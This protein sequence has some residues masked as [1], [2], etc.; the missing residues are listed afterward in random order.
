MIKN[1]SSWP[2]YEED[3]IAAVKNILATGKVNYWTGEEGRL[4]E[5]EFSEYIGV[6]HCV[7]VMNGTV[8]LEAA[9]YAIGLGAGDDV[10]VPAR[11]FIGTASAVI[12]VG[13]KPIVADIDPISQNISV[14]TAE[15]ALTKNTKAIIVV[16]LAG[17]PCDM[18]SLLLFAQKHNLK[19]IEDCAQAIGAT[20][21]G[22]KIG[23]FGNVAAFSFCQDKIMSTGGEGG[24]VATNNHDIWQK[25]W[26]LKDHGKNYDA[27]YHKK[28]PI[29]FR[30]LVDSFGTNL[31]MTE[32][33]AAIGR[34]QLNKINH[35]I[36]LRRR[37]A[38]ILTEKF[39]HIPA[40][41]ISIPNS[42]TNHVYYTYYAFVIPDK[43]KTNWTRDR[44]IEA[45]NAENIPCFVGSCSEIYL[46]EAFQK[47]QL[48]PASR[49]PIARELGETSLM[50]HVHPMLTE[51]EMKRVADVVEKIFELA[52]R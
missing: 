18:Q 37:N 17:W 22:K 33:Q 39:S 36:A 35:W 4:F 42:A 28:H 10:I 6:N 48:Q 47:A 3:E 50:F 52:S 34:I 44:I 38:A 12:K 23:S 32:M 11:T 43:L 24:M 7:A 25:I 30:W 15:A 27:V 46:E 13:A 16:H 20:L 51:D 5:K 29:G 26:S 49:L 2:H 14:E 8:A 40:L 9:L 21:D 45:I 1:L 41:R 31:R 19:I